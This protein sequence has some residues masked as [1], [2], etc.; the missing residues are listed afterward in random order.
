MAGSVALCPRESKRGVTE[1]GWECPPIS[2]TEQEGG[3]EF[4][5]TASEAGGNRVKKSP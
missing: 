5:S 1:A 2:R 3:M 4:R